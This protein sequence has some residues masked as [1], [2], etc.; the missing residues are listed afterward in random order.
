[1]EKLRKCDIQ[2]SF[3]PPALTET[4]IFSHPINKEIR[5]TACCTLNT[6]VNLTPSCSPIG[7]SGRK[8]HIFILHA[9]F[10]FC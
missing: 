5:N 10:P 3:I 1:M 4:A 6:A 9:V 8:L 2:A 7:L